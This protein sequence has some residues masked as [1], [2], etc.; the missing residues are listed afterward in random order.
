MITGETATTLT[1]SGSFTPGSMVATLVATDGQA[2]VEG[3]RG[4]NTIFANQGQNDIVG[5][6]SDMFSLKQTIPSS[7]LLGLRASGSNL[8]FGGS[9]NNVGYGDCTNSAFSSLNSVFECVTTPNGHAHDS[10]VILANNGDI[11][12][13]VGTSGHVGQAPAS[14]VI[15][16]L[17]YL[18]F[19]YDISGYPTATERIIPRAVT[20]LDSTPGGPDLAGQAGSG[21]LE[22]P[23]WR[24]APAGF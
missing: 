2:Y 14:G 19:N 7:V 8:I 17:G 11:F 20:P 22:R 9:G 3:G 12:R 16:P 13:L 10:N 5:G 1:L 6:N 23:A 24:H 18:T 21:P 15:S 4:N